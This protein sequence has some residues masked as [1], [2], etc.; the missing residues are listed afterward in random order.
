MSTARPERRPIIYPGPAE[1]IRAHAVALEISERTARFHVLHRDRL[2][3]A[4]A[5]PRQHAY[6]GK[7]DLIQQAAVLAQ[8]LVASHCFVDGNK[9]TAWLSLTTFLEANGHTVEAPVL[10][11]VVE[12][13]VHLTTRAESADDLARWLRGHLT[14]RTLHPH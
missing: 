14:G 1:V 13:M 2:E 12:R 5:R 4:V 6:Y 7:A 10:S 9:R 11:E 3:A 8:G